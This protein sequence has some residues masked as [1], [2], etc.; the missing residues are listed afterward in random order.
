V[1][2]FLITIFVD[3]FIIGL[4]FDKEGKGVALTVAVTIALE[5]FFSSLTESRRL[6]NSD[7]PGWSTII[8]ASLASA[9]TMVGAYTSMKIVQLKHHHG[10]VFWYFGFIG[11]V[12]AAM[13]DYVTDTTTVEAERDR[14]T[15]WYPP[16][17]QFVG[18]SSSELWRGFDMF[19]E[20]LSLTASWVIGDYPL[21][22]SVLVIL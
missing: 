17:F 10:G 3:G 14:G 19:D 13:Q 22:G 2:A 5:A 7:H 9:L 12:V 6:W 4:T 16:I 21:S 18:R 15:A 11:F 1:V 8:L 20:T